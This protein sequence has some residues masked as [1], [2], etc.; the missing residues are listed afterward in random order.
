MDF[1]TADL[2][3]NQILADPDPVRSA[4]RL[5]QLFTDQ[6]EVFAALHNRPLADGVVLGNPGPDATRA[7]AKLVRNV[8]GAAQ[9]YVAG[10]Q[11]PR[12]DPRAAGAAAKGKWAGRVQEAIANDS[13]GK[14]VA[15]YDLAEAVAIATGDG[16]A[17]F[18][19]GVAK[20]EAKINR[21]FQTLMPQLGAVSQRIQQMPQDNPGQR[22][23][24]MVSNLEAMRALG[25]ARKGGTSGT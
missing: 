22:T 16:G 8:Q 24:R 15:R 21:V 1:E 9:D 6:P 19:Q 13:Y 20:R 2:L 18:T 10:M 23:Q 12:R 7:A 17:A 25:K 4:V 3:R 5:G 14:A 11:A